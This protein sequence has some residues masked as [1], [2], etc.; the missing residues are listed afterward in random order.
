MD[1]PAA[2]TARAHRRLLLL[3]GLLVSLACA[4]QFGSGEPTSAPF[5]DRES[6]GVSL[7]AGGGPLFVPDLVLWLD[8]ADAGTLFADPAGA[9]PA[10]VGD[11][12]ARWDDKSPSGNDTTQAAP[13][14]RPVR[15]AG[16]PAAVPVFDG[17]DALSLDPTRLPTG[18]TAST[19]FVVARL[20]GGSHRSAFVHGATTAG[21]ARSFGTYYA[22]RARYV[23]ASGGTNPTTS[24]WPVGAPGLLTGVFADAAGTVRAD[25]GNAVT[26]AGAF[27]TGTAI[28]EVGGNA[29]AQWIGA[30]HEVLVYERNLSASERRTVETYLA[31]KW[32][33]TLTPAPPTAVTVTASDA[34][35]LTVSWTPPIDTGG[36]AVTGYSVQYRPQ[37][38]STWTT[39][40]TTAGTTATVTG[41]T[42]GTT[43]E[44]RVAATNAAGTGDWSTVASAAAQALWTPADL[45]GGLDLWLDAGDASTITV[46]GGA[47]A[48]WRDRSGNSRHAAQATVSSRPTYLAE[49][50]NGR[51]ALSFAGAAVS[52]TGAS[53]LPGTSTE[54]GFAMAYR[55]TAPTSTRPRLFGVNTPTFNL[56]LGYLEDQRL[57]TRVGGQGY[58]GAPRAAEGADN[59]V[60]FRYDAAAHQASLNGTEEALV[61]NTMPNSDSRISSGTYAL[62]SGYEPGRFKMNGVIAEV[63][64]VGS[65]L[66]LADRER[67]E[68]YLAHRWGTASSLPADHLYRDAPPL[69]A[70]PATAPAAPGTVTAVPGDGDLRV[71][72]TAPA[73]GGTP[74]RDYTVE[75]RIQGSGGWLTAADGVSATTSATIGGLT[76]GTAYE[77][78]VRAVN[79]A[80][81]GTAATTSATPL[82]YRAA[83]LADAPVAYWRLGEPSGTTFRSETGSGLSLTAA[84]MVTSSTSDALSADADRSMDLTGAGDLRGPNT[85]VVQLTEGTIEAWVRTTSP[86]GSY[87]GIVVKQLAYG[88]FLHDAVVSTYDWGTATRRSTGVNVADGQWHHVA[89]TF[90][91][92]VPNGTV[93]YV[94]GQ[95]ALSTTITVANQNVAAVVGAG[96]ASGGQRLAG[97]VD[98]AAI[99]GTVLSPARIAAHHR[100][101]ITGLNDGVA[102][103]TPTGLTATPS[104]GQVALSWTAVAD[105][106]LVG[107]RV[108][109]DSTLVAQQTGASFT[110]TGRTDGVTHTYTVEAYDLRGNRSATASASAMAGT[111]PAAP[112]SV[113]AT[114]T[115]DRAVTVTWSA[116][117][118]GG[119]A[120]SDYVVRYRTSP[121]GSWVTVADGVGT[122]TSAMVT[123]L[124]VG[125]AYDVQVA[126][127]NAIGTGPWSTTATVTAQTLWS[128]ADLSAGLTLW[129]D[130]QDASTLVTDGGAVVEWR[131]R[132][133]NG[134][135]ATQ[136]T[137]ADRPAHDSTGLNGRPSVVFDGTSDFLQLPTL[138][139]TSWT[140]G[141][142][143]AVVGRATTASWSRWFDIGNG[144]NANNIFMGRNAGTTEMILRTFT[145]GAQGNG[146]VS[147]TVA[148]GANSLHVATVAAGAAGSAAASTYWAN[149]TAGTASTT[150]VPNAVTR[151]S[152]YLG[153]S[154]WT[155]DAR[156]NGAISEIVLAPADLSTADR[157]RLEGYLAHK[158][159]TTTS[160]PDGHPYKG[161]PPLTAAPASAPSAPAAPVAVAG[162]GSVQLS[163]TAPVATGT[164][165]RDYVVQ[166]ATDSAF[167][168]PVTFADGLSAGTSAT[169]TGLANDTPYWFRVAAVN[170]A[171][172]GAWSDST[173]VAPT[174]L[175]TPADLS[176]GLAAWY[177]AAAPATVTHDGSGV[178]QWADRSGNGRHAVQ[179]TTSARPTYDQATSTIS[180]TA[181][182]YLSLSGLAGSASFNYAAAYRTTDDTFILFSSGV[183]NV[184]HYGYTAQSSGMATLFQNYGSPSL[185]VNGAAAAPSTR[186]AYRQ[187]V[188]TGA[189][190]V[191]TVTGASVG[192]WST[193]DLGYYSPSYA[194]YHYSGDLNEIVVLT[195]VPSSADRQRLEGYLA[196]KWGTTASLPA[197]HPYKSAPPRAGLPAAP[198]GVSATPGDGSV[199]VQW[200]APDA[201]FVT[202]D[203]VVQYRVSPSGSWTTFADGTSTATSAT[204]TG[205][206]AGTTYDVR[207]AAVNA[208]GTGAWSAT[209]TATTSTVWT[210]ADLPGAPAAWFDAADASTITATGGSVS[211]WSDKSGNGR[212]AQQATPSAQPTS[213]TATMGGRN[214]LTFGGTGFLDA[215]YDAGLNPANGGAFVVGR[216]TGGTNTYRS[217]LTSR[218]GGYGGYNL[219]A[220]Q[221]NLWEYWHGNGGWKVLAGTAVTL[222]EA[223]LL[224]MTWS[225]TTVEGWRNG[226]TEATSAFGMV[227]NTSRPTRIGGGATELAGMQYGWVGDIA[228]V[229]I[230][231]QSVS[232]ADRQ[233]LEGYLA[234]KWGTT[235]LLPADHPYKNAP[236]RAGV[237]AAPTGVSATAGDGS[238]TLQW[239]APN[240]GFATSDYVV[241]VLPPAGSWTTLADGTSTATSATVTGLTSGTTY[242]FRVAAVNAVGTGPWSATTTGTP[243][244]AWT[245]AD[246]SPAP[247]WW[248]DATTGVT[249]SS[250]VVTTWTSRSGN[251]SL[252]VPSG[253]TG[254]TLETNRIN[255]LPTVRFTNDA[256]AGPDLLGGTTESLT[257]VGILREN[258]ASGNFFINLH[259]NNTGTDR[260]SVHGPWGPD[261]TWYWDAGGYGTNRASIS[262]S[263]TAVGAVTV[264]AL[265]KDQSLG[266][267]G[268]S[269]NGGTH[270]AQSTGWTSAATS[271]GLRIGT[272]A[273][274][275][276]LAEYLAFDRRLS[277]A[278]Q[279]RVEG[280]LAH[281]WGTAALLPAGHPYKDAPPTVP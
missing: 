171:G 37:G 203:Y 207:V 147:P 220:S 108:F 185:R 179:P 14:S 75:Y 250:G 192:A 9:V 102:P 121:S 20:D 279:A 80:G 139:A 131:D 268:L 8:G 110:D 98:E 254:P 155:G 258:V 189:R 89:M 270:T 231:G 271:G 97:S 56:Q 132:S 150:F 115:G 172:T 5:T 58:A 53:A 206:T 17:A 219:Y 65:S 13:S 256:L 107:Y 232:T 269:L 261:R 152:G 127:V 62:P 209:A 173:T 73:S 221:G 119:V 109:R 169:V 278:D 48:E 87:R 230:V 57:F 227:P 38:A 252:T 15:Q 52:L 222:H 198:T 32:G 161:V 76:N 183:G 213:G 26:V 181:G 141:L 166:Y 162:D 124:N 111:A 93:V 186:D 99:Y 145:A 83:V 194:Q 140:G 165:I 164:P 130:A 229:V 234:H 239:T 79:A 78:R 265:W 44:L 149:G 41:L 196:H 276:D 184:L 134:F 247:E 216:I 237:P 125:T 10:A 85:A 208:A 190:V 182:R 272:G 70:T 160:L 235:S 84:G 153:R 158:W 200:T 228:E 224:A 217:P 120:I 225:T 74:I 54:Y 39:H 68:G 82:A 242:D 157:Q 263:S 281:R 210:P 42:P 137:A 24:G 170:A 251:G 148:S 114:P 174:N 96:D 40:G 176:G 19:T 35:A 168:S 88:L 156:L 259:G 12:V 212:H 138:P 197:D 255:G 260:L 16:S 143:A 188:G 264:G 105:A 36:A 106:D 167:T 63:L 204:V 262:G 136:G 21:R 113:T 248:L 191:E 77:V 214:V 46:A 238:V 49:G 253:S 86:G 11:A 218:S 47:V 29:G 4:A 211:Q 1:R 103:A 69:T 55:A 128:P 240:A 202:T 277:A 94:D 2:A 244:R 123:G 72:W 117:A 104:A 118:N 280:Y 266:R 31:A 71:S 133:G 64:Y 34:G 90:R 51:P 18:T 233:R 163:W 50:F 25:G 129:F 267:N 180:Q 61:A 201:G 66:S 59:V 45:P 142:T 91:S 146:S 122:G 223:N 126:A 3:A 159:G 257:T 193:V 215:A 112:G 22:T 43:Y 144:Q 135:H 95:P 151:A 30:V 178:S 27:D 187:L 23:T 92:G 205:L 175:W 101:G 67:L 195:A 100:A 177:D 199:T 6:V 116:P 28:A 241:Q 60:V 236:P 245:P 7:Q 33:L 274:D 249:A 81:T 226:T 154:N 273:A 275:H 246:L 243:A